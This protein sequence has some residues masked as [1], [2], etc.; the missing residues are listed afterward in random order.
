MN[1]DFTV[2]ILTIFKFST[3]VY[4]YR[5]YEL[6]AT[7]KGKNFLAYFVPIKSD[8]A[9]PFSESSLILDE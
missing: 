8:V 1:F 2:N 6:V 5:I 7:P 3:F 9:I 4:P